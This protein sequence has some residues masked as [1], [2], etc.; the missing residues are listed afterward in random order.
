MKNNN[1]LFNAS[2]IALF[3]YA[4]KGDELAFKTLYL[5]YKKYGERL[6]KKEFV[7]RGFTKNVIDEYL[8]EVDFVFLNTFRNFTSNK[9]TFR[10]YFAV[11]LLNSVKRYIGRV[12]LTNDIL[13]Q[14]I[15]LD[16]V[17]NDSTIYEAVADNREI[18]PSEYSMIHDLKLAI[19]SPSNDRKSYNVNIAKKV[20][21]LKQIGY[22]FTEIAKLLST[23]RRR[24]TRLYNCII[25]D[26]SLKMH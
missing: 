14:C 2:D 9:G 13:R 11:V 5:R 23:S 16:T 3:E 25:H 21:V 18:D 4:T 12:V 24:V 8:P 26:L 22:S 19:S 7:N 6:A 20:L 17:K 10:A 15:S 1:C